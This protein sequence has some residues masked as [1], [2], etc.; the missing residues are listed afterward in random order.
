[1]SDSRSRP[2]LSI[3]IPLLDESQSLE[4]L[5]ERIRVACSEFRFEVLFVDDGSRDSSW[6]TIQAIHAGDDRFGGVRLRRNYGKSS[7]LAVGFSRVRGRYVV[8]MDADLQDD[9]AEIPGML[10]KL[11]DGADLVSGWKKKRHD[12]LSKTI[13]SRFFNGVTRALSGIPLHDFNCGLKAYR[14]EVVK[15]VR[16]YGELHR[17]IPLLA[18][19]E[20]FDRI[21]EQVV[22]HHPRSYGRTKFGLERYLRGFLDLLSVLFLT[23]FA[24]RPMHFFGAMGS[25]AFLGGSAISLYLSIDKLIYGNP[26]GDRPLLLLGVLLILVGVQMFTTGL[27]GELVVRPTMEDVQSVGVLEDVEPVN[28]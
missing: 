18:H 13:P 8:T 14:C 15:S 24:A 21:E 17:Y 7:A 22:Q 25:L 4:E 1:M 6:N 26:I 12:P 3:V 11:R 16:L 2:E 19:W 5:A 10:E 20:G 9:P 27:I 23:R 28:A